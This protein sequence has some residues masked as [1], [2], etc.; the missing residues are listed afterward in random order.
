MGGGNA[1]GVGSK[2]RALAMH[3]AG[4]CAGGIIAVAYYKMIV[5][6]VQAKR[7]TGTVAAA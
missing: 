7:F 1:S 5:R 6:D 2:S 3:S 4:K